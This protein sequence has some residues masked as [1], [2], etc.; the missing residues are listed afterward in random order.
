MKKS[1]TLI[2]L[3]VVIAI[4]AILASMLLPALSKAKDKAKGATCLSNQKQC[5][6]AIAMY[7]QDYD[8]A[9]IMGN[10][11][12]SS[13]AFAI[14]CLAH[15]SA[16]LQDPNAAAS[17][18]GTYLEAGAMGCPTLPHDKLDAAKSYNRTTTGNEKKHGFYATGYMACNPHHIIDNRL[19]LIYMN[20]PAIGAPDKNNDKDTTTANVAGIRIEMKKVDHVSQTTWL[21]DCYSTSNKCAWPYYAIHGTTGTAPTMCHGGRANIIFADGHAAALGK[22]DIADQ[23]GSINKTATNGGSI[24][25]AD[26][27]GTRFFY[28]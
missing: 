26:T 24:F 13:H 21:V 11:G 27:L 2:E 5:G 28:K 17:K 16:I 4:I 8:D 23:L 1:F 19:V 12:A 9:I 25:F 20:P 15:G 6:L 10:S 3:L 7:L 18:M 22:Q 14:W